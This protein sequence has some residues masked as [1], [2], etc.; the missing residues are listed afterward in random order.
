MVSL[1][2]SQNLMCANSMFLFIVHGNKLNF[3]CQRD[4]C[5]AA[6]LPCGLWYWMICAILNQ[7]KGYVCSMIAGG[8]PRLVLK[9][10]LLQLHGFLSIRSTI[11]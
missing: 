11:I 5:L 6:I 10:H 2:R 9:M 4:R 3:A 1:R 7:V 8:I